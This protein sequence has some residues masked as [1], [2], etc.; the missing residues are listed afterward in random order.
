MKKEILNS[1]NLKILI[2][3]T[4]LILAIQFST[5][6]NSFCSPDNPIEIE[7]LED[8]Q[9]MNENLNADYI[10]VEDI[11]ATETQNWNN[12]KGFK[13]IGKNSENP[14]TGSF[15][16]NGYVIENLYINRPG[17]TNVGLFGYIKNSEVKRIGLENIRIEG[18]HRVG[19]LVGRNDRGKISASY[20][21]CEKI[22]GSRVG[23][24]VGYNDKGSK[25]KSS[26]S[27]GSLNGKYVGGLVGINYVDSLVKNS[28]STCK[29]S[30]KEQIGSISGANRI[31]GRITNCF[32]EEN[33]SEKDKAIGKN[34]GT[35]SNVRSLSPE[36]MG[37][38]TIFQNAGW[39]IAE[40]NTTK[41]RKMDYNW[42]IV[43]G[44]TYPFLNWE[45][46][47]QSRL[48]ND[49]GNHFEEG[50]NWIGTI[51]IGIIAAIIVLGLKLKSRKQNKQ[52]SSK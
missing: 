19:G 44:V 50:R 28:Y 46:K 40:V 5:L 23:G 45:V 47:I 24:L 9:N 34:S 10:L 20:V 37:N 22:E 30:G 4:L 13:P 26:H 42:N 14:F 38:I 12:G 31:R 52:K 17:K 35:T 18:G 48:E 25:V 15:D 11:N 27:A 33:S 32:F 6:N 16:G 29:V 1:T 36:N 39:D 43:D 49:P 2:F 41:D 3:S 51:L 8:L 21:R 7:D